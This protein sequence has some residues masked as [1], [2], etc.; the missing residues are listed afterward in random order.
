MG[1]RVSIAKAARLLGVGRHELCERLCRAG[2]ENFEGAVELDDVKRIS[3]KLAMDERLVGE[4]VRLIRL[5]ARRRQAVAP[6]RK[7]EA[8]LQDEMDR[9]HNQW[10]AE[11]KRAQEY[12]LLFD[13]LIDELGHWQNSQDLDRAKFALEFSKWLCEQFD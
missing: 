2:V 3:P 9:L 11:R 4:R 13:H 8:E 5:S 1:E 12:H 10:L 7:K 6:P